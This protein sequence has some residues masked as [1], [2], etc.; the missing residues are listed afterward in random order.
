VDEEPN[1]SADEE[2]VV[3]EAVGATGI[4]IELD[5]LLTDS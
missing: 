1:S 5:K 3:E 4:E 2:V